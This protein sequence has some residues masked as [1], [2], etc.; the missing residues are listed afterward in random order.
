MVKPEPKEEEE[1]S[2]M[3]DT[4]HRIA[5]FVD[6]QNIYYTTRDVYGVSLTT[7]HCGNVCRDRE[8]LFLR[9]LTPLVAETMVRLSFRRSEAHWF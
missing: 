7:E 6:V 4:A 1:Q 5:V 3:F 2:F 8:R 9:Q